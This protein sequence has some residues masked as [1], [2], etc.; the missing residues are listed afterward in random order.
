MSVVIILKEEKISSPMLFVIMKKG[1]ITVCDF[2]VKNENSH[3]KK[4][5]YTSGTT[6][7][8]MIVE[9]MKK[10]EQQMQINLGAHLRRFSRQLLFKHRLELY[11]S[12]VV[13]IVKLDIVIKYIPAHMSLIYIVE[14]YARMF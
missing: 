9:L 14:I 11:V 4:E 6:L 12:T 13:V 10:S 1:G 7:L 8:Y 3:S 5:V 2:D